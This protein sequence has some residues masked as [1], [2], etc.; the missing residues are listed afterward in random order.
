MKK[1]FNIIHKTG[2][3]VFLV[4]IT[5]VLSAFVFRQDMSAIS[6]SDANGCNAAGG[7]FAH[8]AGKYV[9]QNAN[10]G[11]NRPDSIPRSGDKDVNAW[12]AYFSATADQLTKFRQF[13]S[14]GKIKLFPKQSA[15]TKYNGKNTVYYLENA[16]NHNDINIGRVGNRRL[17]TLLW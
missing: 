10:F 15:G 1:H 4:V 16:V 7:R 3:F 8:C 13:I 12:L 11:K 9:A 5:L 6:A 2:I 14:D 17:A